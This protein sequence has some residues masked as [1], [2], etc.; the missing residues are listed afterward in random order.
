MIAGAVLTGGRSRRFGRDK[1]LEKFQGKR[2]VEIAFQKLVQVVNDVFVIGKDY[3]LGEFI[4]DVYPLKGPLN[5][6]YSF[7]AFKPTADGVIILPCDTPLVP[8]DLLEFIKNM[9]HK[10]DI[11][12]P[13]HDRFFEPLIGYYNRK[14]FNIAAKLLSSDKLSMMD[15]INFEGLKV[16]VIEEEVLKNFGD[17]KNY[18]TN[19]NYPEDLTRALELS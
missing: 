17:P 13:R 8:V 1:C 6:I 15:L 3:G 2:L 7:F 5:A 16:Y 14:T 4:P 11:V 18:F 19:I 12:I 9:S 10:A